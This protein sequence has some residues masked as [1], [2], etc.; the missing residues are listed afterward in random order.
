MARVLTGAARPSGRLLALV[1]G[2]ALV[3]LV[4]IVVLPGQSGRG[5]LDD[6]THQVAEQLRCPTC[7]AESAADS[8][9]PVA[10]SMRSEIRSQLAAGRSTSQVISW[11]RS[12]YGDDIVLEPA[13]HGVG[14]VLWII[15][16][17]VAIAAAAA[18]IVVVRRR[19]AA[20]PTADPPATALPLSRVGAGVGAA[21]AVA[22]VVPLL[23]TGHG[24]PAGTG[25]DATRAGT[26]AGG[27]SAGA[28]APAGSSDPVARA[29]A[30]LR[31]GHP[32][33]AIALVRPALHGTRADRPMALLVLGLA[34]RAE[35]SPAAT[36]T[37]RTFLDR[38]P[39]HPAADAV[40]RLLAKGR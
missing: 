14:L 1:V 2:V 33:Q 37:L 19:R 21:A 40:R 30:L 22:V 20:A 17:L 8:T 3:A 28:T 11:F 13:H 16:P 32:K 18:L 26:S 29:F 15:P 23:L 36:G 38:Y 4:L 35:G 39:H 6:R 10:Q 24:G 7:V 31:A 9:S 27:P 25:G 12:R 34:Q 5:S